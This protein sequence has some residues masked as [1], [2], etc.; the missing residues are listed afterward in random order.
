MRV[1]TGSRRERKGMPAA[2]GTGEHLFVFVG[3][4]KILWFGRGALKHEKTSLSAP[5]NANHMERVGHGA[6]SNR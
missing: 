3:S 4:R 2:N 1:G 6:C 5:T